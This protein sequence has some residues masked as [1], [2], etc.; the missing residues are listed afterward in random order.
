MINGLGDGE[1]A[2]IEYIESFAL[3]GD[4]THIVLFTETETV[5]DQKKLYLVIGAFSGK[6]FRRLIEAKPAKEFLLNLIQVNF[7]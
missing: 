5:D 1:K 6:T 7:K 3:E 2:L 4:E